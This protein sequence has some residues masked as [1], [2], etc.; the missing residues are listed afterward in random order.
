MPIDHK[1]AAGARRVIEK[2]ADDGYTAY[3]VG[4]A[5]RDLL[6]DIDPKDYDIAT[7]ATPEQ[8][9]EVFGRRSRIIG[10]RFRLVHVYMQDG[11]YEVSTFRREPTAEERKGREAD[12]GV[13][14]WSDNQFG[15]E[16]DD[17]FRRDFTVNAMYFNPLSD[18]DQ[19]IDY[20]G[21]LDDLR[22]G[23]VRTIGEAA[24]RLAEDPVRMLR[25]CKLQGQYGFTLEP[26][27]ATAMAEQASSMELASQ[28]RRLEELYKI[29]HKPFTRPT[30]T[31]C[32][33]GGI[34]DFILPELAAAWESPEGQFC[35]ELL[36]ARDKLLA[37]GDIYPS[38]VTGLATLA[39]PFLDS[40]G[41]G[42]VHELWH[43]AAGTDR[44][45]RQRLRR[46]YQ[47]YQLPRAMSAKVRDVLLLQPKFYDG[48]G[49]KRIMSH[50][51]YSRARDMFRT[52]VTGAQL[53]PE[54]LER[55]PLIPD[56]EKKKQKPRR[57]SR[58][59]RRRS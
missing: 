23:R 54:L 36:G 2:L 14:V 37:E 20:V 45:I 9:K 31:A 13:M 12:D 18:D 6:L 19:I 27:V 59:R 30:F 7:D 11:V 41:E 47:L 49:A 15:S 44:R 16:R 39:L 56:S 40:R 33:E 51:E 10:R 29:L 57:R 22:A 25:A 21:G 28:A 26:S 4:G 32:Y 43:N 1:I 50:P 17:A 3:L 5:V 35:R 48:R 55:W 8:V 38:R 34:L 58:R 24:T 46:F 52:F 53:D 42:D